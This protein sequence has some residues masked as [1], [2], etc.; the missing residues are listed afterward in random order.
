MN[1][2][3]S[4]LV[5]SQLRAMGYRF[6][7]RWQDADVVLYNT[8]SVRA[9]AEQKVYSRIGEVGRLKRTRPQLILG[10]IGCM[11]EREGLGLVKRYPQ[12]DLMCGPGELDKISL[13]VDNAAKTRLQQPNGRGLRN[14]QAALQGNRNRRSATLAAAADH[15]EYLD[16]SRSF[17]PDD[18]HGSAY[19]RITRGCN[20]FCTYCV[21]PQTRG[22]E[23]HRPPDH[24]VQE[25]RRLVDA[26]VRQITLLG[27]TVNHYHYQHGAAVRVNG[28]QQPQV[29]QAVAS[30]TSTATR[31]G[32][33]TRFSDLLGRI[34][35]EVDGLQRLRFVTSFPRDFGDDILQVMRDCPAI[36]RY[37]HL[38]VQSGSDRILKLMNRG[39]SVAMYMDLVQRVRCHLPDSEVATDII[40]GF[41]TETD[42][43]HQATADLLQAV[44]CKNAFIFKYSARPGTAAIDRYRDDVPDEVKRR[45]NNEMLA[46]Q[47]RISAQVH[48]AYVGRVVP[49]FVESISAR[50]AAR[51]NEA[52]PAV[53][54]GWSRPVTQ[55]SGRT[56]GDLIVVFDGPES[57]VGRS[58]DVVID[59]AAP[60]TLFGHP[61]DRCA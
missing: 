56:G 50:A 30:D 2:L 51:I 8:C 45:R 54:L 34:C 38:P 58:V 15:L 18:H 20:K 35:A 53:E 7:D 26:G 25:C 59:R 4:Q 19:V 55:L 36:C 11:A 52:D 42:A 33:T 13:L 44:G 17:S 47:S 12:I 39:Y 6:I 27:Q 21:V 22:A 29:G 9:H 43:D 32:R 57:L 16:L 49:V 24:I 23:V 5:Q 1:V 46:V 60:L 28:V 40:C 10:V 31:S 48:A 3:D 37:L 14:V 61:E 41:P